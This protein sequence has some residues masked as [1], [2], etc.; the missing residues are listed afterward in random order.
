MV[1]GI[2]T[3]MLKDMNAPFEMIS[4][5]KVGKQMLIHRSAE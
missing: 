4:S 2:L 3:Y 5:V 1:A